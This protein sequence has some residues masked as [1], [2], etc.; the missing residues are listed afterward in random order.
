MQNV[1]ANEQPL[2]T[3]KVQ[4]ISG[5]GVIFT[6]SKRFDNTA[7]HSYI[8]FDNRPTLDIHDKGYAS[9]KL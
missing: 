7:M 9:V 6:W 2:L 5:V 3:A 4:I 8:L 1:I